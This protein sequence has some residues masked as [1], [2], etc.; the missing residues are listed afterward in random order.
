MKIKTI[1]KTLTIMLTLLLVL[2]LLI[3]LS[4]TVLAI[5]T[6]TVEETEGVQLDVDA[7]DPDGDDVT[8]NYTSPFDE[9]GHWQTSY[10]DAGE[11]YVNITASDGQASTSE[12]IYIV[13]E[14]KNRAPE[15]TINSITVDETDLI[16]LKDYVV[17]PDKDILKYH[18]EIFVL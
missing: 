1:P 16:D 9:S 2:T 7:T 4:F 12:T 18:F 3:S 14:E 11:Y 13:V 15:F 6:F 8:F 10:E 17:D 5:T